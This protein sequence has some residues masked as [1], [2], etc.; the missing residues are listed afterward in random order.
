MLFLV[1]SL[2]LRSN[3]CRFALSY[4]GIALS[5]VAFCLCFALTCCGIALSRVAF[6]RKLLGDS[7]FEAPVLRQAIGELQLDG[8]R[9]APSYWGSATS[10]LPLG[11]L[12]FAGFAACQTTG[13]F[14]LVGYCAVS[15]SSGI[16]TCRTVLP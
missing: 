14:Q 13:E 7:N 4:C 2:G 11:E 1:L 12:E 6:C 5:R 10:S 3:C 9:F 15:S 16:S 8:F